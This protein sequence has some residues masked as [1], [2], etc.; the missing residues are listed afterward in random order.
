MKT[1]LSKPLL[2]IA[3][4]FSSWSAAAQTT[5]C[6][7]ELVSVRDIIT[8]AINDNRIPGLAIVV[9]REGKPLW[10]EGFGYA[11][12]A[13]QTPASPDSIFLLASVSKPITATGLM[14]LVDAGKID[15][16]QPINTY[17]PNTKMQ[18]HVADPDEITVRHLAHHTS[19]LATHYSFFFSNPPPSMDES[20]RRFAHTVYAPG[21][22]YN[23]SNLGYGILEYITQVVS[24]TP[25]RDYMEQHVYDPLG[26][27]A[28]SDR[29]RPEHVTRRAE[30]YIKGQDEE[31]IIQPPYEFD[32]R[33]A[34]A[35]WS[36]A[37]DLTRLL[38]MVSNEG[39]LDGT[40]FLTPDSARAM[41]TPGPV[42]QYGLGWATRSNNTR[43]YFDH[44]GGMPGV[45]TLTSAWPDDQL[46]LVILTNTSATSINAK[47]RD[48]IEAILLPD[49]IWNRSPRTQSSE[50]RDDFQA[51]GTWTGHLHHFDGDVPITFEV[52]S[53]GDITIAYNNNP[54]KPLDRTST[55]GWIRARSQ[56]VIH[57]QDEYK[58]PSNLAFTLT[59]TDPN[60]LAGPVVI[61][62][63]GRY[64][65]TLYATLTREH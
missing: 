58:G 42:A 28:T 3:L 65:T 21:E 41:I 32:H 8:E 17:L 23:Y 34:S 56:E 43:R 54:P 15:L 52:S 46:T 13:T 1:I 22:R 2:A 33:G 37:H 44:S 9:T 29:V 63:P 48:E 16:D 50:K 47:L 31:F 30:I 35:V 62:A 57:I 40:Q 7:P 27:T 60:T 39:Q 49:N 26:M 19:G 14:T 4:C 11:D 24:G 64:M 5:P 59:P 53:A 38:Q 12:I 6:P 20:I 10:A 36:S 61:E 25:W 51:E 45:S 55:A 18:S